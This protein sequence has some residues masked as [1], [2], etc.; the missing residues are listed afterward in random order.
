MIQVRPGNLEKAVELLVDKLMVCPVCAAV[1][2]APT[3]KD[4]AMTDIKILAICGSCQNSFHVASVDR[5]D[6]DIVSTMAVVDA[7]E[8][9]DND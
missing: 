1:H 7:L 8:E 3:V 2:N 5:S 9:L 6:G 4:L